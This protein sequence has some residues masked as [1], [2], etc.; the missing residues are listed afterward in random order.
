MPSPI[1]ESLYTKTVF[2]LKLALFGNR[3][4]SAQGFALALLLASSLQIM[5]NLIPRIPLFPWMR[6]GL[7]Y[8]IILPF[9]L[10]F[11]PG[12]AFVLLLARN[13]TAILYGGQPFSTFLIGTSAGAIALL[14]IGPWVYWTAHKKWLG[15]LG[16]S[17]ILATAFNMAQLGLVKWILIRHAGFYFMIGPMLA[18]SLLSGTL[19]AFLVRYSETD[20]AHMFAI[21]H[22]HSH[23]PAASSKFLSDQPSR[24]MAFGIG[25]IA[26]VGLL[27]GNYY[28]I[29]IPAF[30]LL[31]WLSKDHG[32]TL[33]P[34]WPF[35]FYVAYL[36]LFHTPGEFL[37][38]D[39]ITYE[40]ASLF[41]INALRLANTILLGRWL[42]KRFPWK[43]AEQSKSP[44]LQ[45]F[46]LSLPL[47]TNIFGSSMQFGREIMRK[48]MSGHR[49]GILTPAF[50]AWQSR[51][52]DALRTSEP[53]ENPHEPAVKQQ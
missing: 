25:L 38:K 18:W 31:L 40:G 51:M 2:G 5:E 19:V 46:L 4:V 17:V 27:V 30:T 9:L 41:G 29:Q 35:F 39:W 48:F 20:L 49:K 13:L 1:K 11:G 53:L 37:F 52:E 50:E 28:W 7:S 14:L 43:L 23:I 21:D 36:H 26:L 24:N 42:S 15:I 45:G 12:A 47:L 22:G 34:A 10:K 8:V 6:M 3:K 44:Y 33:I 16:A 32:K